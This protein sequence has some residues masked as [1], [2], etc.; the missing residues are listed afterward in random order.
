[1]AIGV[2]LF[3]FD[4][5]LVVKPRGKHLNAFRRHFNNEFVRKVFRGGERV[6]VYSKNV[7]VV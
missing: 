1:L 2:W 3:D 7:H 4:T 6:L 5:M